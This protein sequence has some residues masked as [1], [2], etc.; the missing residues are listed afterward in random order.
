MEVERQKTL[1]ESNAGVTKNLQ[2]AQAE[3]AVLEA[4]TQGLAK[5]LSYL[6]ISTSN[7]SPTAIRQQIAIVAPMSGYLSK[8][9]FHN[10]MYAQSSVSLMDIISSQ[11]LHLELDVF[12]K[13]IAKIEKGQKISYTIPALGENMYQGEV[14]V[15]GKEFNSQA[16][17]VR[18][19]GHLE[20][21]KPKFLKDLFINAKIWLND[22]TTDALPEKAIIKD[23]ENAF[24]YVAKNEKDAK[25]IEFKKI[26]IIPGATDNGFTAVKLID[27]IP[28]GLQIVTKGAYYVYAQSKAGELEHE[29]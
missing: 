3:V 15:I 23:G 2:N 27:A 26:A 1:V 18:I 9:N 10:G 25:E 11:H 4:K 20:G 8:I 6:G 16:K 22:N 5:Q 28:E 7:L 13:D 29:H 24:I 19:H 17:T 12:E 21:T 14:S